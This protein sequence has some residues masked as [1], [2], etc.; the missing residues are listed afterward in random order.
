M[1]EY[2]L[3]I[4]AHGHSA[5]LGRELE[6]RKIPRNQPDS[7]AGALR[8]QQIERAELACRYQRHTFEV[9]RRWEI[10]RSLY[11]HRWVLDRSKALQRTEPSGDLDVEVGAG[12]HELIVRPLDCE[13]QIRADRVQEQMSAAVASMRGPFRQTSQ[14]LAAARD[15]REGEGQHIF[16]YEPPQERCARIRQQKEEQKR[17]RGSNP[18][19]RTAADGQTEGQSRKPRP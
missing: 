9:A 10:E 16:S 7:L 14:E 12:L 4:P 5:G 18:H 8:G 17:A 3:A 19:M 1:L 15:Q 2:D 13:S 11:A 6:S